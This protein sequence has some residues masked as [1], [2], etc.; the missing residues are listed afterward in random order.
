MSTHRWIIGCHIAEALAKS[1]NFF[2][3]WRKKLRLREKKPHFHSSAPK[4]SECQWLVSCAQMGVFVPLLTLSSL[5]FPQD[6]LSE[7]AFPPLTERW[8][9]WPW[10]SKAFRES[11]KRLGKTSTD[12]C[13]VPSIQKLHKARQYPPGQGG[14]INM[15]PM[16]WLKG[17]LHPW[18]T[19][20]VPSFSSIRCPLISWLFPQR[21]EGKRRTS[22][23]LTSQTLVLIISKSSQGFHGHGQHRPYSWG[24]LKVQGYF[25]SNLGSWIKS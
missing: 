9:V 13:W 16:Q 11:L 4:T 6:C 1:S 24:H 19:S 7:R 3:L 5:M 25:H 18:W 23:S 21:R 14:H 12:I 15:K 20:C 17:W 2:F 22:E 8:V 10:P